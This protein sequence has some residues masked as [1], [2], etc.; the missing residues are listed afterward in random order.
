MEKLIQ[1]ADD[2]FMAATKGG[3]FGIGSV[4]TFGENIDIDKLESYAKAAEELG[5]VL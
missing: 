1:K 5:L 4:N 3:T 2:G